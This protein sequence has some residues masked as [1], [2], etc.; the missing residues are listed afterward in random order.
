MSM[1]LS[2]HP[3]MLIAEAFSPYFRW[4]DDK[5]RGLVENEPPI[6]HIYFV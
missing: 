1:L 2:H 5:K 6:T 3:G 4:K